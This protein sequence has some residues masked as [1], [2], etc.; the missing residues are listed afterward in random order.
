MKARIFYMENFDE[1][2]MRADAGDPV[3]QNRLGV[4]YGEGLGMAQNPTE[5]LRWLNKSAGQGNEM[6]QRNINT[7]FDSASGVR[8]FEERVKVQRGY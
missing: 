6:A 4:M 1:L 7:R 5:A 3:A 8:S 2:R